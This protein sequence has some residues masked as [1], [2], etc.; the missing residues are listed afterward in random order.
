[1]SMDLT[2]QVVIV[3]GAGRG[4]G[5]EI[6]IESAAA[7]AHVVLVSRTASQLEE[8]ARTIEERPGSATLA[9]TDVT[10]A[11]AITALVEQTLADL[12]KI[13]VLVNNAGANLVAPL[14]LSDEADWRRVFE[15]NVFSVFRL[16]K[17]VLRPMIKAKYGRVINV[18]SVAAKVGA[19]FNS[20]YASSKAA[21]LGFTKS[22][23]LETGTQGITVNALCPWHVDT[24]LTQES[25]AQRGRILGVE[26]A[27]HLATI[28]EE[29]LQ[30]RLIEVGEVAALA[31]FLMSEEAQGINGQCLNVCGGNILG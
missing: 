19:S 21:I 22:I 31:I 23:A 18:A 9:P 24:K 17:L 7:G 1:M 11:E 8:V 29:S 10:D 2:G 14:V 5:R 27:V 30:G 13:D 16:T 12:G 20:A 15:V 25:M 26:G 4:I 6:A 28:A 3:T